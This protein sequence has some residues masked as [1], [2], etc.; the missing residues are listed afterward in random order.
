MAMMEL[1]PLWSKSSTAIL[2]RNFLSLG[3]I[4]WLVSSIGAISNQN[5][6][7]QYFYN[8]MSWSLH[9]SSIHHK[10]GLL[11]YSSK[12]TQA[13][14]FVI[15]EIGRSSFILEVTTPQQS[16]ASGIKEVIIT[17]AIVY[18]SPWKMKRASDPQ[19]VE[20]TELNFQLL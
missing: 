9:W 10:W 8:T 19:T 18:T 1:C 4:S 11:L 7:V 2:K 15:L 5:C 13:K 6:F 3:I 14:L 16:A 12:W 17:L 20:A